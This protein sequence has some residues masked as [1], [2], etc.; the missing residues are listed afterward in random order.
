MEIVVKSHIKSDNRKILKTKKVG[1]AGI[2][3]AISTIFR[4]QYDHVK[5]ASSGVFADTT[6]PQAQNP[7][8]LSLL[9]KDLSKRP[10]Q[11]LYL[12]VMYKNLIVTQIL[13]G[14]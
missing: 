13:F 4:S 2:E 9:E 10:N 8:L 6:R 3:P 14:F 12:K 1:P 11:K 7:F 5:V